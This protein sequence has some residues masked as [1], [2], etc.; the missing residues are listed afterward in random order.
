MASTVFSQENFERVV[1]D[2]YR[3]DPFA[4]NFSGFIETLSSDTALHN[5]QNYKQTD[6]TGYFLRGE[7]DIFNP[8]SI[9]A[10]KVEIFF[11]ENQIS[12]T[13]KYPLSF[14]TY[15][16]TAYFA[17]NEY[18][19]KAIKKDFKKLGRKMKI[20]FTEV[21]NQSLKGYQGI[22]DGEINSYS[23]EY[24]LMPPAI[25]SWQTLKSKQIALSILIR[26]VQKN[27]RAYHL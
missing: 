6:S 20:D 11:Y 23:S 10:G 13:D 7:Y 19:R 26:I 14:Y 18:N 22:E 3:V 1:K 8:F 24:S 12:V 16:L 2:Y 17:D 9:N 4:G 15:Q 5:K 27:N 21:E 25:I